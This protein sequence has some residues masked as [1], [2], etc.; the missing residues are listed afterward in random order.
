MFSIN[1]TTLL[2]AVKGGGVMSVINSTLSPGYGIYY[3]EGD[4]K[5]QKPF[6]PNSFI[7]AEFAGE[8][9]IGTAPL[10]KGQYASFNK[11]QRPAE[12]HVTFAIEGWTGFSG[13]IP[14]ITNFSLTSRSDVLETLEKMRKEATTFDI[15]TPDTAYTSYDLIKYDYRIRADSGVTLL[16]VTAVFEAVNDVMEVTISNSVGTTANGKGA[17]NNG[18]QQTQNVTGSAKNPEVSDVSRA[19]SG[20]KNSV[21]NAATKVADMASSS[22]QKATDTVTEA[23]SEEISSTANQLNK[24]VKELSGYLT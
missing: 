14:N 2:N 15:E 18:A 21:S 23:F 10:E 5:G 24:A 11:V 17:N 4:K 16:I 8:A 6:S 3:A 9:T 13:S 19:L 1:E 12:L 7:V 20:L 22:L